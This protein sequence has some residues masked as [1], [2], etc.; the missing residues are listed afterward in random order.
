[1]RTNYT[2]QRVYSWF[3]LP[4]VLYVLILV[5]YPIFYNINISLQE[6][7]G[8]NI[9]AESHPYIGFGNYRRLMFDPSFYEIVGNTAIFTVASIVLQFVIGFS[10]ALFLNRPFPGRDLFRAAIILGWVLSPV[11]V[12]T[13]WRW[14]L[15][16]DYGLL[17]YIL[18]WMGLI[19]ENITWLPRPRTAMTGI[20]IANVWLGIPFNMMLLTGGLANLPDDVFESA[21][22][23]GATLF[24]KFFLITI[25]MMKQ[26]I[27]ATIMLGFIYTLKVFGLIWVM[28]KG[29]PVNAT[30]TLP[31]W[32]YRYSFV[33]FR[34]SDGAAAANI[35]LFITLVLALGYIH[36][37]GKEKY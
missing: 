13:V 14:L 22:I 33:L 26:T 23:D 17:N 1:M 35:L 20:V 30:T 31:V 19:N 25:P 11:V 34:F 10:L 24:Q 4:A 3:L 12:G 28:T 15:N 16:S 21:T 32:S 37:F 27:A 5:F 6:V 8:L 7:T 18:R 2:P 29:G 36:Y 9:R